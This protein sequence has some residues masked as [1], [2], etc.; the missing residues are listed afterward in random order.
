MS[1]SRV[2]GANQRINAGY[3]GVGGNGGGMLRRL[4]AQSA[5]SKDIQ[6]VAVCDI[7]SRRKDKAR[8]DAHLAA[9]DVYHDYRDLVARND[10][11]AVFISTPDHW[12]APMAIDALKAGKDV[13]L[14][15]PMTLTIEEARQVSEAARKYGRVL[16]VG[17]QHL[18]DPR[19]AK[20][21]EI[22]QSGEI[23][24]LL[25]AQTT[26]SRNSADGEWNYYIDEEAT[27]E[28]IDWQRWLGSAPKRA[29]SAERYFRW[30]KYWDYSGGIATDLFYHRLGPVL[31]VMG[32]QFPTRVTASGGIYVHKDREVPD[33][34]ATVVEYPDFYIDI[35]GSTAGAGPLKFYPQVIYG[36]KGTL[37]FEDERLTVLPEDDSGKNKVYEVPAIDVVR[38]HTDD[39]FACMRSRRKTALPAEFGY[40]IMTAIKLGVDSYR[41]GSAKVFDAA[42]QRVVERAVSRPGYEGDGKNHESGRRKRG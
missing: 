22:V 19:V 18:S 14:Q 39:F 2:L 15:K 20:A 5:A 23:G 38:A 21:R 31:A 36:H 42:S 37:L 29:F 35:S 28:T 6:V 40:Q 27:P 12:H 26:Y 33:T 7:Y 9:K 41:E 24:E 25:W 8:D 1:A 10:V 13:Y 32:P 34:Y 11:D 30:R 17:S 16:Q 3:I 4:V